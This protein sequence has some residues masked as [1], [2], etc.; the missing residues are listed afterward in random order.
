MNERISNLFLSALLLSVLL[1]VTC[2]KDTSPLQESCSPYSAITEMDEQGNPV[3]NTDPEDWK[4][5]GILASLGAFPNPA[6]STCTI[7]FGLSGSASLT[8]TINNQPDQIVRTLYNQN[9]AAG[10]YQIQWNLK[11]DAGNDLPDCIYRV[12]FRAT[13]NTGDTYETYGD[14]QVRR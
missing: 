11:D 7:H 8:I 6:G 4:I 14:V 10:I 3:G 2:K 9:A 5:S 1:F 12:Y 13:T